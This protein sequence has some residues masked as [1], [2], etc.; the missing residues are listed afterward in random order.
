M[1]SGIAMAFAGALAALSMTARADSGLELNVGTEFSSG[2]YGKTEATDT[3]YTPVV[4]RYRSDGMSL[5]L[6]LPYIRTTG[7]AAVVGSLGN[8]LL[9]N[10]RAGMVNQTVSGPGDIE[11]SGTYLLHDGSANGWFVE[12]V[13][14]LKFP[15][16][17]AAKGLGTGSRD[18]ALE[19]QF[20]HCGSLLT[21]FG[22]LGWRHMGNAEGIVFTNSWST[23]L[24]AGHDFSESVQLGA[25]W[26]FRQPVVDGG[27]PVREAMVYLTLAVAPK[28]TLQAYLLKGYSD[29]APDRGM[30]I[31][32]NG[33]F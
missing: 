32:W 20:A 33:R 6:T 23:V 26:S 7:P 30:G 9:V 14:K 25:A 27:A 12:A 5:G 13:G 28:N 4:V 17:D 2:T 22:N 31:T 15:T 29:S 18:Y 11:A 3:W 19:G 24:G 8:Q 16:G 21:T 10:S 1:K